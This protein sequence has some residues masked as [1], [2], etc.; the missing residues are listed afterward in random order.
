MLENSNFGRISNI[1]LYLSIHINWVSSRSSAIFARSKY[2]QLF[3][4]KM[5]TVDACLSADIYL[6]KTNNRNIRSMWEIC[7][8]LTIKTPKQC[9]IGF[10]LFLFLRICYSSFYFLG[11]IYPDSLLKIDHFENIFLYV[12]FRATFTK[13]SHKKIVKLTIY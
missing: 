8:K 9:L 3:S 6:L 11:L 4:Q 12:Y 10:F 7:S 2:I 13:F 5:R 1:F